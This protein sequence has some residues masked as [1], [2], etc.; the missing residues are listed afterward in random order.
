MVLVWLGI[1]MTTQPDRVAGKL[2]I[3]F[4]KRRARAFASPTMDRNGIGR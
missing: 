2:Q 3:R 4:D 1:A